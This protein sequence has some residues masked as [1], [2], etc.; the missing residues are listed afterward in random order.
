MLYR[1]NNAILLCLMLFNG[2]SIYAQ[3]QAITNTTEWQVSEL[4]TEPSSKIS[5]SGNPKIIKTP[6]GEAVYFD[7]V[8]DAIFLDNMALNSLESFTVEMIF[9]PAGNSSFEQ[10]ILHIGEVSDDRM[11]LEIRAV[12]N[13]WYFDG[14]V[15][16]DGN[17]KA[18]IDERLLHSLEK[19]YHVA[20]VV[21][22]TS[23]TTYVNGLQELHEDFVFK[24]I[25]TGKTSIGVRLN[26]RSWF[27]GSIYK[28]KVS[29]GIVN[30]VK[31][32]S[33]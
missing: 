30:P 18:L 6:Y 5:I 12:E 26:K 13:N 16:S 14:Y 9:N 25:T 27:K 11:L 23:L 29:N 7:G 8:D 10:R 20:F 15:A 3:P 1:L 4:L 32:I 19:W 31:F 22:P 33:K 17:K 24:P 28:I 2:I 21:T